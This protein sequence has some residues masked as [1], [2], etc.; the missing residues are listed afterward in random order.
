MD[1]P[2]FGLATEA[3]QSLF[4]RNPSWTD[5]AGDALGALG[6][7]L[8]IEATQLRPSPR[9][10]IAAACGVVAFAVALLPLA[11][12][13]S[14]YV[15]RAMNSPLLWSPDSRVLQVFAV[16]YPGAGAP[17]ELTEI[18]FAREQ[19]D[20]VEFTLRNLT[21]ASL[22]LDIHVYGKRHRR[23]QAL[24]WSTRISMWP[25]E[26]TTRRIARARLLAAPHGEAID[27]RAVTS[28][29]F[30]QRDAAQ[31]PLWALD[32]LRLA[33]SSNAMSPIAD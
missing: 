21:A 19:F 4:S 10:R 8:L 17:L 20:A 11:W 22:E 7:L 13:V 1:D 12:T 14:A 30:L 28:L 31:H 25:N 15:T 16:R 26:V 18:P 33:S 27:L 29:M 6:A 3:V 5:V 24:L 2:G 32:Q 9:R 23:R